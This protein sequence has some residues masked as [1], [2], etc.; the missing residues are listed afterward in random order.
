MFDRIANR[1]DLV[2]TVLSGGADARWRRRAAAA[3]ELRPGGSAL[4]VACGSG[5]LTAEL[6]SLAVPPRGRVVGLDFS[7]G[8]LARARFDHPALT[9]VEA[10]PLNCPSP[11]AD[12]N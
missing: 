1:Y 9:S 7:A 8:M 12:F 4:D 2:N 11:D 3:T 5:K 6:A 10:E